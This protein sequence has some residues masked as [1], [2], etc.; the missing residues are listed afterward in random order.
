[1]DDKKQSTQEFQFEKR[2]GN[3]LFALLRTIV[4][5]STLQSSE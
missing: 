3:E 2:Q 4:E 5:I 1:M